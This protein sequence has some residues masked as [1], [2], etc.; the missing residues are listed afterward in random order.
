MGLPTPMEVS[1]TKNG[2]TL[3]LPHLS[4]LRELAI[5]RLYEDPLAEFSSQ[6]INV[7]TALFGRECGRS[8]LRD[9]TVDPYTYNFDEHPL[10]ES[11]ARVAQEDLPK[12]TALVA[13]LDPDGLA[14]KYP[15]LIGTVA[16]YLLGENARQIMAEIPPRYLYHDLP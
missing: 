1:L 8:V 6:D 10:L 15:V 12:W 14:T 7:L 11:L 4:Y 2:S 16:S 5:A 3:V 9:K 13:W